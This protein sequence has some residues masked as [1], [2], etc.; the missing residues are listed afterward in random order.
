MASSRRG[1]GVGRCSSGGFLGSKVADKDLARQWY[2]HILHRIFIYTYIH[3]VIWHMHI[4]YKYSSIL[5]HVC[6][7][8]MKDG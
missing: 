1:D 7:E 4:S 8:S 3:S 6:L 2:I 5:Q